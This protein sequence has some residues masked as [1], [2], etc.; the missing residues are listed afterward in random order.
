VSGD[1]SDPALF[2]FEIIRKL[3]SDMSSISVFAGGNQSL[4]MET[5]S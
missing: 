4:G 1:D 5:S 2:C 3:L